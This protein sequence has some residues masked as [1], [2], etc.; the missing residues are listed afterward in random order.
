MRLN[1]FI[2][3]LFLF[4]GGLIPAYAA[5][6]T[7]S[8]YYPAPSGNYNKLQANSLQLVPSTMS[9]IQTEYKCSF[10][11]SANLPPCPAGLMYY[12]TD[13]KAIYISSG[14]HWGA[15]YAAACVPAQAC[16]TN[17]NCG[18][19]SCGNPCGT[20]SNGQSCSSITAGVPGTCS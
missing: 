18:T 16:S 19:D 15:M 1:S 12:D 2:P 3:F 8:T 17:L 9:A 4:L 20:C 10:D 14:T 6:Q 11:P 7:L 5:T 13:A